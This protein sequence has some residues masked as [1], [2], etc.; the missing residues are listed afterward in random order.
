MP[1]AAPRSCHS[2]LLE[3]GP[4]SILY[5]ELESSVWPD[6]EVPDK[7]VLLLGGVLP[8]STEPTPREV[9]R[10]GSGPFPGVYCDC[11]YALSVGFSS[12][13]GMPAWTPSAEPRELLRCGIPAD[14]ED[15]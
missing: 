14:L 11:L 4:P 9:R 12:R 10:G 7:G 1:T 15:S 3:R 13:V 8:I 6:S 5:G 2:S